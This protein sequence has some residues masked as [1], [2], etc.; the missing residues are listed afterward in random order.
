MQGRSPETALFRA[1]Y[2]ARLG[3]ILTGRALPSA[4]EL[5]RLYPF[6]GDSIHLDIR[7]WA[8]FEI[9]RLDRVDLA[10]RRALPSYQRLLDVLE[11]PGTTDYELK[12]TISILMSSLPKDDREGRLRCFVYRAALGNRFSM[13]TLAVNAVTALAASA[14]TSDGPALADFTLAWAALGWLAALAADGAFEPLSGHALPER[15][16]RS[17]DTALRHGRA[18]MEFLAGE[19]SPR[20]P[21]RWRYDQSRS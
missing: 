21:P 9:A 17:A 19:A 15:L 10:G 13:I 1:D 5:L 2:I 4:D 8:K 18:I 7:T 11:D 3:H 14:E 6:F 12:Q 16:E 20:V